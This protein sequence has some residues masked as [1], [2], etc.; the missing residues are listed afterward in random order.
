MIAL[1]GKLFIKDHANTA[2]ESVRRAWGTLCGVMGVVLN[3]LLC[4]G[5]LLA[6]TLSGSIAI[7]ADAFNNL[8]DALSSVVTL[9]G[10]RLAGK[11]PDPDH[12]FGHGRMEYISG[13]VVAGLILMMGVELLR[14]SFDKIL[15]PEAVAFSPVAAAILVLAVLVKV[16]MAFYNRAVGRKIRSTAM[17]ATAKDSLC[18]TISTIAVLLSMVATLF[19]DLPLDGY[20]GLLVALFILYAAVQAARETISPLLGQAPD[21]EFV[22]KIESLVLSHDKV[23]GIHDLVVHDYGPGRL[24]ISLHAEVSAAD[25]VMTIHDMIDN[26]ETELGEAL[27]CEAVIHMDPIADDDGE[28]LRLRMAVSALVQAIDPKLTIHDFR[29]V[30]GPTHTNLIF[31]VVQPFGMD[32]EPEE[33]RHRI[34]TAVRAMSEGNYFAVVKVERSYV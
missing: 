20:V 25:D 14:T 9:L 34:A 13:L 32:M 24:L 8:S 23:L 10:F 27:H 4:M 31:D 28:V 16:Y 26:I 2:D 33:L 5:K 15:H 17:A 3:L 11:K 22:R 12:P 29:M 19:T 6:G 7:T 1:L 18:D 21:E 30:P